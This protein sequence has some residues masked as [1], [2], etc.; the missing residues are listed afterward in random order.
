MNNPA[1][2][3]W[4]DILGYVRTQYPGIA[5]GWFDQ[6]RAGPVSRGRLTVRAVNRAQS[7]YLVKQ[8]ARPFAEATQA[9]TGRLIEV[10]FD[11]EQNPRS[12]LDQ[13]ASRSPSTDSGSKLN[14]EY[15]FEHFVVGHCNRLSHAAA[16]AVAQDPG[17]AYNPLFI[18]GKVG[19]GKT[20][21]IQAICHR[22]L[23]NA[24][25]T[26][27]MYLS[28][29]TFVNHFI[30]AIGRG[31]LS[32]FRYRYRHVDLLLID[33]IQF[34]GGRERTQEE[35]FHTF[36][37]LY[38]ENGQIVL[39][40]D[41]PP[42]EIPSLEERL[43]SRFN[44]GLVASID[45]PGLET[46]IAIL[47]E[48]VKI[49]GMVLPDNVL[50]LVASSITTSVRELEGAINRIRGLSALDSK[51]IGVQLAREALGISEERAISLSTVLRAVGRK[52]GVKAAD[53]RGQ[54]RTKDMILPRRVAVY[55]AREFTSL[56][57]EDIGAY[58]GCRDHTTILN[59]HKSVQRDLA[60]DTAQAA[61]VREL[62]QE[63]QHKPR[64]SARDR[65]V[66]LEEVING[67]AGH[68]KVSVEDLKSKKRSK[69]VGFPRQVAMFLARKLA[70]RSLEEIGACFGGRGHTTVLH[71]CGVVSQ[72]IESDPRVSLMVEGIADVIR[73][74]RQ[75]NL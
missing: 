54:R 29:E 33:D 23:D 51:P 65:P 35:F 53:V 15:T 46:R 14:G 44:S 18:H 48:K 4:T 38:Q 73:H 2:E 24:P 34:L 62:V 36:N 69:S 16:V 12:D 21:L 10:V 20:H 72:T 55:L 64:G 5:R 56:P 3:V 8:C 40:A 63:L 17:K 19:L 66:S 43:V 52:F 74:Q 37:T 1:D 59:G 75:Y 28:C 45:P 58:F 61:V 9:A 31:E 13:S 26:R 41:C 71:A 49:R 22:V 57:L 11:C 30:Q 70:N 68:F 60:A 6:L 39:T 42:H 27:I 32:S 7:A 25:A 47:R 50:E 67:V